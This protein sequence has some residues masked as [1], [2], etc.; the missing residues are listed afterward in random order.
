M[1]INQY[2]KPTEHR[3]QKTQVLP[4]TE[5]L[6]SALEQR[7]GQYDAQL[8]K[9][10]EAQGTISNYQVVGDYAKAVLKVK[11]DMLT[12]ASSNL[13][14]E[15][16]SDRSVQGKV[17]KLIGS[18]ADD[19]ELKKHVGAAESYKKYMEQYENLAKTGKI[20]Q[21][22]I[23]FQELDWQRY[24][25]TGQVTDRLSNPIIP[26]QVDV[27]SARQNLVKLLEANGSEAINY[28]KDGHA[29]KTG[30]KGVNAERVIAAVD[31]QLN[32]YIMSPAGQQDQRDY[33]MK[34]H[35]GTIDPTKVDVAN[36]IRQ[37]VWGTV[38]SKVHSQTTTNVDGAINDSLKTKQEKAASTMPGVT[39]MF[40]TQLHSSEVEFNEKG[41]FK[42]SGKTIGEHWSDKNKSAWESLSSW[43]ND[44]S[45]NGKEKAKYAPYMIG[46]KLQGV[47]PKQYYE[48]VA[49]NGN[50][51]YSAF[52]KNAESENWGKLMFDGG[53][54]AILNHE[55][56]NQD[57]EKRGG[58]NGLAVALGLGEGASAIEVQKK[59]KELGSKVKALGFSKPSEHAKYGLVVSINGQEAIVKM[60]RLLKT[61]MFT[62]KQRMDIER[63][64]AFAMAD[65]GIPSALSFG[66]DDKDNHVLWKDVDGQVKS[67]SKSEFE[68]KIK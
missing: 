34:V 64:Y 4:R 58:V 63:D 48:Q 44:T 27:V 19:E 40:K 22:S 39:A 57:G 65:A 52:T 17:N 31:G 60:D 54:G 33:Y 24:K 61:D 62:Q 20:Q 51:E 56:I 35:M 26:E 16:L 25:K 6:L 45:L 38:S 11:E 68:K 10:S 59:M 50:V 18:I 47:S 28:L 13:L 3:V 67:M 2:T 29:Y 66:K 5:L 14:K 55:I 30:Y 1:A 21:S 43:Y 53:A 49:K 32:S 37:E 23:Y 42:G 9:L 36:Y 12:E 7:Q 8:D 15:D 41:E 46:A